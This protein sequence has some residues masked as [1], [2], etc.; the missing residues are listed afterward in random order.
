[1]I[2]EGVDYALTGQQTTHRLG[3]HAYCFRP[4][5]GVDILYWSLALNQDKRK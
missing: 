2:V 5:F 4:A 3:V 1:M